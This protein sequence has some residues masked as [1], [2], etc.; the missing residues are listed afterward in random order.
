MREPIGKV[1]FAAASDGCYL[2]PAYSQLKSAFDHFPD[3]DSVHLSLVVC[4]MAIAAKRGGRVRLAHTDD[5]H[6]ILLACQL[7]RR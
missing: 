4:G 3:K 2:P 6:A 1:E 5:A 7:R